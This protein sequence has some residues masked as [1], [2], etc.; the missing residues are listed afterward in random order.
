M[1][2]LEED[3][4]VLKAS[5][6]LCETRKSR[7]PEDGLPVPDVPNEANAVKDSAIG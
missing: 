5:W 4:D 7:A 1:K 6:D 2:I 3:R